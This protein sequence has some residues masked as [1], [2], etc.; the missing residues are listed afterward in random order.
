MLKK[1]I[2]PAITAAILLV[3]AS[4]Q[5][6]NHKVVPFKSVAGLPLKLTPAQV[7]HRLG[8][9]SHVIRVSGKVAEYDYESKHLS[10]E[11]DN[12]QAQDRADFVGVNDGAYHTVHGIH[13]GS[14]PK[15][16]HHAFGHKLK[17]DNGS[18]TLYKGAP[19]S[20]NSYRTDFEI[21]EGKVESMDVQYV[22]KDF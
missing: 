17:C 19:G 8:K 12:T 1:L 4:A 14:S 10:V 18:C 7:R 2:L 9:P 20:P 3:P 6:Y 13:L 15:Q 21:F 5:A 11:F 16:L 22:F